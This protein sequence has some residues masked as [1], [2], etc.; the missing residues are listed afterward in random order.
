M[1]RTSKETQ[2]RRVT[3][4]GAIMPAYLRSSGHVCDLF[5]AGRPNQIKWSA[6]P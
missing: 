4:E 1:T 3:R 2:L 6:G 5:A